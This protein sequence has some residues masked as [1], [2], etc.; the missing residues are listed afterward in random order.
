MNLRPNSLHHTY[1]GAGPQTRKLCQTSSLLKCMLYM[2]LTLLVTSC[3]KNPE[4]NN[5]TS[6]TSSVKN[7][8]VINTNRSLERYNTSQEAFLETLHTTAAANV[9]AVTTID[10]NKDNFP[11]DTLQ[12][13]L[14]QQHYDA[15]YCIGAKA[16]GSIDYIDPDAPVFFS[17]VLNW[18]RFIDQPHYS[19]IAS[20]VPAEAQFTWFKYFFPK[21]KKVGVLYS[22]NNR[23]LLQEASQAAE[24]LSI[25]LVTEE[26]GSSS[27]LLAHANNLLP[28]VDALW[29]ISDSTVLGSAD[30]AKQLFEIAHNHQTPVFS[31]N[32][33]FVDMGAVLSISADIA[34]TGR[35]AA[36]MINNHLEGNRE[37]AGIQFPAGSSISLNLKRVLEYKLELNGNA[38]DSVNEIIGE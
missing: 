32:P 27:N 1:I 19:G 15:I 18:R 30:S 6:T 14:N 21:I 22:A 11:V 37:Q 23:K 20:G 4:F 7:I 25:E 29:L 28:K 24:K 34:T 16:L 35:Q 31:Y 10:L 8:L 33:V 12:D 13:I 17:S 38:L 2:L 36:L 26:V 3:A 5:T 9:R